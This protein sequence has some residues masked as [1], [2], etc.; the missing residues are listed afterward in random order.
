MSVSI[1]ISKLAGRFAPVAAL[2]ALV[3]AMDG[4]WATAQPAAAVPPA[5][6]VSVRGPAGGAPAPAPAPTPP[7]AS[8]PAAPRPTAASD[9]AGAPPRAG[10]RGR[11]S[12]AS[13]T[14][15]RRPRSSSLLLTDGRAGEGRA[16][17]HV[18][19]E[20]R[21]LPARRR[22]AAR[23]G[24]RLQDVQA[25]RAVPRHQ[26]RHHARRQALTGARSASELDAWRCL[27][28]RPRCALDAWRSSPASSCRRGGLLL[29]WTVAPA[30]FLYSRAMTSLVARRPGAA[31]AR[32]RRAAAVPGAAAHGHHEPAG[33]RAALRRVP[34]APSSREVGYRARAP[35][36]A[37][38]IA[39]TSSSATAAPAT[40]P[41][42]LL[43][44]HLDVVEADPS[45]WR[46]PP[47]SGDE[48]DGCLW[49]RGAIDMK[50]MAA[51]CTAIMRRLAATRSRARRA[52]SS[53]P[54]SPTRRP[55]ATSAR[56]S[57]S[58]STARS[59]RPSTRSARS[60]ASRSTSATRRSIRS[61]SPRRASAGCARASPASPATARCRAT[62]APSRASARRSPRSA[63]RGC[64]STRRSYVTDFLDALRARQPAL[65]QPLV[66]LARAPAP[67]RPRRAPRPER[68]DRAQLLGA[69]RATPPPP[70]SCA[71]ARRPTSSP[72]SPSSRSTAAPCPA[73]P[74]TTSCASC[75]PCSAPTSSSRSSSRRR[76]S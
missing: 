35:R 19:Q 33:Q 57:S 12:P 53:S 16:D 74:T 13:S 50:N 14:S 46:H 67:A 38:A 72:A 52:T 36:G 9:P 17:R 5:R 29:P 41:P 28:S 54:P 4:T 1:S 23:E 40:L 51:M 47:F 26:G 32:R 31:V 34:R 75:A 37:A 10:R 71:R 66:Q 7:S 3:V 63:A 65:I 8:P 30:P 68:V 70:R 6:P 61:R 2:V 45:K 56:G 55:A 42:L 49:G 59:S 62:T 25:A 44:A 76:R 15:T 27:A 18:A 21:R 39:R 24:L 11:R 73:R 69:A 48:H 60:A 64:P 43:T 20:E 58:S 22:P